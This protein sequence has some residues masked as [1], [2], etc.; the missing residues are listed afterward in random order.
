IA[1]L[2][3]MRILRIVAFRIPVGFV[4]VRVPIL[5]AVEQSEVNNAI[6]PVVIALAK[7]PLRS[8]RKE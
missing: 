7:S 4:V 8:P 5:E 1:A 3:S 6:L 2:I